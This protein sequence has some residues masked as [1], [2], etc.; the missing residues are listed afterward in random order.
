MIESS[1][2]TQITLSS[3]QATF[4]PHVIHKV[5]LLAEPA[6][7]SPFTP[8]SRPVYSARKNRYN[9]PQRKPGSPPKTPG[10]WDRYQGQSR[11]VPQR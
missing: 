10:T 1:V 2:G 11:Y 3:E 8:Q 6:Q 9:L 5:H 4:T 7:A